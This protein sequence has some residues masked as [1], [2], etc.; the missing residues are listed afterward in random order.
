[1][2]Y[3]TTR[4]LSNPRVMGWRRGQPITTAAAG[5][6][7]MTASLSLLP[8]FDSPAFLVS[9]LVAVVAVAITGYGM[10][11]VGLPVI[12]QPIATTLAW[13]TVLTWMFALSAAA[14]F[15]FPGPAAIDALRILAQ[16]GLA[17]AETLVAPVP[18]EPGLVLL[19]AGGVGIVA[20]AVD[21]VAV[22]LRLPAVAGAPLIVLASLPIAVLPEGLPWWL[23]PVSVS[24]WLILL[25]VDAR[26]SVLDWGPLASRLNPGQSR[27]RTAGP[28]A[29]QRRRGLGR[30]D[31]RVGLVAAGAV[32]IALVVPAVIP[33]LGEPVWGTG[34]GAAVAGGIANGDGPVNLDPFVSLR[35]S[36]VNESSREI[37]RYTTD[38]EQPGYLRMVTL[39]EFDGVTWGPEDAGLR[40]PLTQPLPPPSRNEDV[41]VQVNTYSIEVGEL[42]NP[43]LPLPYAATSVRGLPEP[44]SNAW[45]WEPATRTVLGEGTS[46]EGLSYVATAYDVQPTRAQL[47]Q[48]VEPV[49]AELQALTSL[50]N[51][52]TPLVSE[53]ARE[54]TAGENSPYRQAVA[55]EKWFTV[56]GGFTYSTSLDAGAGDDPVAAFLLERIGY[57]EQYAATMALMARSLGIPARVNVG[58]TSGAQGEDGVWSVQGRNAHAWPELWFDGIGWVWFEPTPRSDG[59]AGVV[60]PSYSQ[61]PDRSELAP[62]D[63]PAPPPVDVDP[64]IS[65]DGQGT[66]ATELAGLLSILLI[67][68]AVAGIIVF[69]VLART[70]RRRRRTSG[71]A[72]IEGA[73]EELVDTCASLGWR[74]DREMT[75]RSFVG[76]LR[77]RLD[78]TDDD[79]Q[80]LLRLLWWVEQERY[81]GGLNCDRLPSPDQVR[82][83]LAQVERAI[84]RQ[85]TLTDRVRAWWRISSN[86]APKTATSSDRDLVRAGAANDFPAGP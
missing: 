84:Q 30:V 67:V 82:G 9:T 14:W 36:L 25:A 15:V 29:H 66:D 47:R 12:G 28:R 18:D 83:Q 11:A 79:R 64:G 23:L 24:G 20:I 45:E 38:A 70:L 1:M 32:A 48:S 22:S 7:T 16:E 53:L 52:L 61:V 34:R 17:S 77:E 3:A 73:W 58:F 35:R 75:P 68:T 60:A 86:R 46:A 55:L 2:T 10:R 6:A 59:D 21:A 31:P 27:G 56:D 69:P 19:A 33:G 13:L 71:T 40:I 42:I 8:L 4:G 76:W 81:A 5:L 72:I 85:M 63:P 37:L 65:A 57:C 44:L 74:P 54:V 41:E 49:S 62:A 39:T 80:A 78:L 50:P 43:Q 51:D 26:R